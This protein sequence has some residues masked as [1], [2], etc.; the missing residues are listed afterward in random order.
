MN[1]LLDMHTHTIVS[2]HAYS[3]LQE[4][5][6]AAAERGLKLLGITDHGPG[7]NGACNPMYFRNFSVV[8]QFINGVEIMM[9]AE[10][11]ILNTQGTLDLDKS[12]R[13]LLSLR[14]AGFHYRSFEKGTIEENT[15][16]LIKVIKSKEIDIISHPGDGTAELLFERIVLA[17]KEH[18]TLLEINNSSLK[19]IRKKPMARPNNIEILKLCK[20][21]DVPVIL[22]SDAHIS[23]DIACY[24][25]IYELLAETEFPEELIVNDKIDMFKEIIR[26]KKEG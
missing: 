21:Y 19:P 4:M 14:I 22:G 20:K 16:G 3:T 11:N 25:H 26:K 24:E 9:G 13:K 15:D 10:M 18:G 17:A 5:A 8:P 2:G 23:F 7:M 12:T 1:I 6:Q